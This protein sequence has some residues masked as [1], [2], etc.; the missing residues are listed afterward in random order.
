MKC[1]NCGINFD[2]SE[3][4]CPMCGTR[5]GALGRL[6]APH[7]TGEHHTRHTKKGCTHETFT[8]KVSFPT[9]RTGSERRRGKRA[10]STKASIIITAIA[11]LAGILPTVVSML[12]RVNFTRICDNFVPADSSAAIPEPIAPEPDYP[13]DLYSITNG[14]IITTLPDGTYVQLTVNPDSIVYELIL[15]NGTDT[16]VES[17]EISCTYIETKEG[18]LNGPEYTPGEYGIYNL[19]LYPD[20]IPFYQSYADSR[21]PQAILNRMNSSDP[22]YLSL[23][24]SL[25][26]G[27]IVIHDVEHTNLFSGEELVRFADTT[28]G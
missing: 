27:S 9:P 17:G 1:R 13:Q 2:D 6:S 20:D 26:D 11:L 16:Y 28:S 12:N 24:K 19:E 5:A 22:L 3:H 15:D 14:V 21:I 4:E 8:K 7:Y 10:A 25:E 23:Y 18:I